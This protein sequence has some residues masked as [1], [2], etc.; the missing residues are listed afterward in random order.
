MVTIRKGVRY[1]RTFGFTGLYSYP[2]SLPC[3]CGDGKPHH[4]SDG[5]YF[6]APE[7]IINDRGVPEKHVYLNSTGT[8]CVPGDEQDPYVPGRVWT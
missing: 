2:H 1:E 6:E 4:H 8:P 3:V 5:S 7:I